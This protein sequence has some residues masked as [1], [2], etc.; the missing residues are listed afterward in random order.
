MD[1]YIPTVTIT[2]LRSASTDYPE[3]ILE[4]FLSLPADL[5]ERVR[6]LAREIT[7]G[8]SN[9]YDKVKAIE[10]YL[11]T[12]Y[13]YDLDISP[14]PEGQDVVDY[15][16]FD[17]RRGYCDYYAT[18]MV[19]LTRSVGIPVRFVSGY[20]PG[21]YDASTT[22]YIVRELDAHSW[23]EVY[24]PEIGWIEFEPT[25]SQPEI[26][27]I[28]GIVPTLE[29]RNNEDIVSRLLSHFR[30]NRILIWTMPI[31]G[32]L[33]IILAYFV[34]IEKWMYLRLIPETAIEQI[35]QRFYQIG[36]PLAGEWVSA[37]TS[38][39]Y[40][41]K[42]MDNVDRIKFPSNGFPDFVDKFNDDA[43]ALTDLYQSMLFTDHQ[44]TKQDAK[45]TWG[46]WIRLRWQV[47][48]ARFNL[49]IWGNKTDVNKNIHL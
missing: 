45:I 47:Y 15:F 42:L 18:S 20:A 19:V 27:R 24:F 49:F 31:L 35:Y 39:E 12:N 17:L 21:T 38:S 8:I 34:F 7:D 4:R 41:T 37:E 22:Q 33:S 40:L 2:D 26:E 23:V 48:I 14:P 30:L 28:E 43:T 32:F 10:R 16:L 46:L 6:D 3:D 11:R 1:V 25:P 44:I 29:D 36:R 5:P 13:P 9:P